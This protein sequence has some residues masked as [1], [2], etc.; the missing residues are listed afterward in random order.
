[1]AMSLAPIN[2]RNPTLVYENSK[3]LT[4]LAVTD[5]TPKC[6]RVK[7][8]QRRTGPFPIFPLLFGFFSTLVGRNSGITSLTAGCGTGGT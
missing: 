6:S 7:L 5:Y 4:D 1:M 8:W 2:R 3:V